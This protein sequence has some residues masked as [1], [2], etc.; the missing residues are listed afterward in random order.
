LKHLV[1]GECGTMSFASVNVA[2]QRWQ[3]LDYLRG[4]SLFFML[5]HLN[6][7]AW[8]HMYQWIQHTKWSGGHFID[9]VAPVFLFCIG[10]A[11]PLSLGRRLA[12]GATRIELIRHVLVR[13]GVLVA[14][15]IFFNAYPTFDWVH[16]RIPG[17]L[18]RIGL[19]Y[20]IVAVF[21]IATGQ[22]DRLVN[23]RA[24]VWAIAVV[25]CSYFALLQWVPVPGYG[26]P[27]FDP[28]GSW[29]AFIDRAVFTRD[30]MFSYWPVNGRVEFDP[31]GLLSTW[32]VCANL[33]IGV[34]AGV[35]FLS[36]ARRPIVIPLASGAILMLVAVALQPVCP[37]IKNIWTPTFVLFTC[38]FG[39]L[40]L[41]VLTALERSRTA[42][43]LLYPAKIFGSNALLAYI[44]SFSIAPL[45]DAPILP[46]R[47]YCIRHFVYLLFSPFTAPNLAS[48]LGGVVLVG[49]ILIP[50]IVCHRQ[51]WFLKL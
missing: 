30:H 5:L 31:D 32:P 43:A 46:E 39:L 23:T 12:R 22:R 28:I 13:S 18:Q 3:A 47:Y 15:G 9:L 44:I 50:L 42:T 35:W 48:L 6:N 4:L 17:V 40:S 25:L 10:A 45:I 16:V 19:T 7:G 26:A 34:L 27:R 1:R 14:L 36:G 29:P 20:G 21:V 49:V 41:G 2:P 37:I 11:L 51:R 8:E 33:L 38:G 24:V